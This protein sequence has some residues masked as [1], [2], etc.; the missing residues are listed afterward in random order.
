MMA[1]AFAYCFFTTKYLGDSFMNAMKIDDATRGPANQ[2][3]ITTLHGRR[4]NIG[5]RISPTPDATNRRGGPIF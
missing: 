5:I 2:N 1:L 3:S 4:L